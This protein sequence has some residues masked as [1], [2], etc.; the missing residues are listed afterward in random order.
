MPNPANIIEKLSQ[1]GTSL[2]LIS[3]MLAITRLMKAVI[4]DNKNIL[5]KKII[6]LYLN[7]V[8]KNLFKRKAL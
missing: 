8:R 7:F 5:N 2:V 3:V 1:S 4:L 6:D